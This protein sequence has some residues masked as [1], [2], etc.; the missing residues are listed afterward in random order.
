MLKIL[1]LAAPNNIKLYRMVHSDNIRYILL[2]G[3]CSSEHHLADPNYINIG[4][5]QLIQDRHIHNVPIP[6][7]GRLGEYI[8]FY[9]AGHSPML[10]MIMNGFQGVRQ[11]PQ[12]D[13]VFIVSSVNKVKE[14]ELPFLFTDRNAKI[15]VANFF[16]DEQEFDK[17]KWDVITSQDWKNSE[18]D[19]A[20]RDFKQA[21]FLVRHFMPLSGIECLVVKTEEK[22]EILERIIAELP[23]SVP[24][25][26]DQINKLYY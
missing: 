14:L 10:F 7:G 12:E 6:N 17:L 11:R 16:E 18:S 20:R 21:E 22:K 24:V 19:I 23:V 15:S 2:N 13:I 3:I 9:F 26:V 1:E 25:Y 5:S 8:P 4:H